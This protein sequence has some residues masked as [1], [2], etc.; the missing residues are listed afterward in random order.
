MTFI[1][2]KAFIHKKHSFIK[3]IH[4]KRTHRW[5]TWPCFNNCCISFGEDGI[6]NTRKS[7]PT[8]LYTGNTGKF[9]RPLPRFFGRVIWVEWKWIWEGYF[10]R[11]PNKAGYTVWD[12]GIRGGSATACPR[13]FIVPVSEIW[14]SRA[15]LERTCYQ[16]KPMWHRTCISA[17]ACYFYI[18]NR[19]APFMW[20]ST[21]LKQLLTYLV[22]K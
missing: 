3:I 18:G 22:M 13:P 12:G 17:V 4:S 9:G 16:G 11:C 1:H 5:P 6:L 20:S 15:P 14:K 21:V 2:E 19:A 7:A 10:G 8:W